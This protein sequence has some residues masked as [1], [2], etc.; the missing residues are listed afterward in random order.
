MLILLKLFKMF[1]YIFRVPLVTAPLQYADKTLANTV[2]KELK[3][4]VTYTRTGRPIFAVCT[5][6]IVNLTIFTVYLD[7]GRSCSDVATLTFSFQG[8]STIRLYE[9]KASQIQCGTSYG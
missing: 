3:Y 4:T 7:I 5:V 9:I 6:F 8:S 2:S 1:D